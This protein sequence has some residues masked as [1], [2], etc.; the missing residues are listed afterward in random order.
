MEQLI[1]AAGNPIPTD[2][3][4]C[5]RPKYASAPAC[6]QPCEN[7]SVAFHEHAKH[8]STCNMRCNTMGVPGFGV[9]GVDLPS[10]VLVSS[11]PVRYGR[12]LALAEHERSGE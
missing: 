8:T 3:C 10:D 6:C 4:D 1:D 5:G 11:V 2:R 7:G 9:R 12:A